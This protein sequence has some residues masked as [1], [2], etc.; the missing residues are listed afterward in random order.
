M[1]GSWESY[2]VDQWPRQWLATIGSESKGVETCIAIKSLPLPFLEE[3]LT[4]TGEE[5]RQQLLQW[6]QQQQDLDISLQVPPGY[7]P[8]SATCVRHT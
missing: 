1:L 7:L 3:A 8:A 6:A 2:R 4:V 5:E